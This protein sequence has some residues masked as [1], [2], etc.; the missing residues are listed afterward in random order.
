MKNAF[1]VV[2]SHFLQ[3]AIDYKIYNNIYFCQQQIKH[4]GEIYS[5]FEY[6]SISNKGLRIGKKIDIYICNNKPPAE[7]MTNIKQFK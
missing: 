3:E 2:H 1:R 4:Q 6:A 7:K 5:I